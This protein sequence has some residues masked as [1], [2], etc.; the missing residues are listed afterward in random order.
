MTDV[1]KA[2]TCLAKYGDDVVMYTTPE[3][4]TF[5]ATNTTASAYCRFRYNRPFFSRFH[6]QPTRENDTLG[7]QGQV[8][9][10]VSLFYMTFI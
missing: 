7:P 3:S 2:L 1:I 5:S 6:A 8:N 4:L 9:A 10:K